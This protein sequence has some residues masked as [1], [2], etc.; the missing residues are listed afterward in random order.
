MKQMIVSL[1]LILFLISC[2]KKPRVILNTERH[3][4]DSAYL[5]RIDSAKALID[6]VCIYI[7]ETEYEKMLDSIIQERVEE[8]EKLQGR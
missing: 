5:L 6:S 2:E 1:V 3:L 7:R 8:I 4:V